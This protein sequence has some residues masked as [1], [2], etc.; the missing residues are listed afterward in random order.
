MKCAHYYHDH[1]QKN[2]SLSCKDGHILLNFESSSDFFTEQGY[3][4]DQKCR[5]CSETILGELYHCL[6]CM[7]NLCTN[8]KDIYELSKKAKDAKLVCKATHN[9]KWRH[10]DLYE[11][12]FLE[13]SCS[14]CKEKRT[15]AGFYCCV[16]C[17]SHW[18]LK[19]V[20]KQLA[21]PS[22]EGHPEGSNLK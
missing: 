19:C 22:K 16:E 10:K 12:A 18:C 6:P 8:C 11:K 4:A 15:G 2:V 13:L 9:L 17:P 21:S 20:S 7:F 1:S 5:F 14:T 3:E